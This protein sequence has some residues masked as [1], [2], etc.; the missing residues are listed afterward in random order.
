MFQQFFP[1]DMLE[2]ESNQ[3]ADQDPTYLKVTNCQRN[4]RNQLLNL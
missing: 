1:P 4:G 3:K 2:V